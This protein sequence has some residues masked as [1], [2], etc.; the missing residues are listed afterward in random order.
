MP[1]DTHVS[2]VGGRAQGLHDIARNRLLA[3]MPAADREALAPFLR[4]VNL[5]SGQVLHEPGQP[6]TNVHFP[7]AGAVSI[8]MLMLSGDAIETLMV[9][10]EGVTDATSHAVPRR[11]SARA[12]VQLPGTALEIPAYR[13]RA[14]AA[15]RP[16]LRAVLD[17]YASDVVLE[18]QLGVACAARHP[19]ERRLA[20]WLLRSHDRSDADAL[21]LTQEF[22]GNMLGAQR[23]TVTDAAGAL[24][25]HGAIS[26]RRG[27]IT[28]L[29]RAALERTACECY[30][31]AAG[32]AVH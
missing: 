10:R 29:D 6:I 14:A 21:P 27:M 13:L 30:A 22:L 16:G 32:R 23:T 3:A 19:L 7:T 24:Q 25:R 1:R 11:A 12:I 18:L 2:S 8:V 28:I 4:P 26:Y 5:A 20:T 15:E 9:G 17:G 31:A